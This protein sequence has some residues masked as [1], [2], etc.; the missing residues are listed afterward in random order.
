[1]GLNDYIICYI[2][3]YMI[4]ETYILM[5]QKTQQDLMKYSRQNITI[6]TKCSIYTAFFTLSDFSETFES[7]TSSNLAGFFVS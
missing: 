3:T 2:S 1:M 5:M 6:D 7:Y 4:V